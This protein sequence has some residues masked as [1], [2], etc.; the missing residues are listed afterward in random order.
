MFGTI[1]ILDKTYSIMDSKGIEITGLIWL[2]LIDDDGM[3]WK[4]YFDSKDI[5]WS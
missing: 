5:V 4:G 2:H 1:T 3:T